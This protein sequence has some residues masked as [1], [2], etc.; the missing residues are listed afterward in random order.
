MA[1]G[2]APMLSR[3]A[4]EDPV[5]GSLEVQQRLDI[6]SYVGV[7]LTVGAGEQVGSLCAIAHDVG[8]YDENELELLR[9]LGNLLAFQLERTAP[10]PSSSI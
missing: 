2:H 1:A 6:G 7:P 4:S 3:D 5:H 8:A 10:K 9:V